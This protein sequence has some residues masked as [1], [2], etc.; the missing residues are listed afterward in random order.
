MDQEHL[1]PR[2]FLIAHD[3][4]TG[5]LRI[6][7]ELLRCGLVAAQLGELVIAGR[8]GIT[9]GRVVVADGTVGT[10]A[11]TIVAYMMD[12]IARQG[13]S[14]PV[15]TWT[16]HL[17]DPLYELVARELVAQGTL[18]RESGRGLVRQRPDR[19][20]ATDLLSAAAPRLRLEHMLRTP[21]EMDLLGGFTAALVWTLGVDRVLDPDLDRV[22][23]RTLVDEI[24]ANLP[25]GLAEVLTGVKAAVAAVSLTIRR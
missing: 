13:T 12:S 1:A 21:R 2:V 15:R 6:S 18:R 5:K 23:A 4:F 19:F 14:H 11:N 24:T 22:A 20:P 3:E 17:G 25:I 10:G 8:L 7:P 9:N 16:S